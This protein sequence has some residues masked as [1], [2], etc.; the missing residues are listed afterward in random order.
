M[1]RGFFEAVLALHVQLGGHLV[2]VV[3]SEVVVEGL[4]VATDAA[5]D[6]RGVGCEDGGRGRHVGFQGEEAGG[7]G[8]F[9]EV[10]HDLGRVGLEEGREALDYHCRGAPEGHAFVVVAVSVEGVDAVEIPEAPVEFVFGAVKAVE[11]NEDSHRAPG[12]F[13]APD[14]HAHSFGKKGVFA[15]AAQKRRHLGEVRRRIFFRPYVRTD[16]DEFVFV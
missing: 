12:D 6:A 4:A 1:G 3:A 15:P 9:V 11:F 5:S 2:A 7:G 16:E 8:P 10:S 13:P 14:A